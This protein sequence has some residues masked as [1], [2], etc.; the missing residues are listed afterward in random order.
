MNEYTA[1][2][3]GEVLAF[4]EVGLESLEKGEVG[5]KEAV[6]EQNQ[7][8]FVA[9]NKKHGED[10]KSLAKSYDVLDVVET[11]AKATGEKLRAMREIY[12]KE[13]DWQDP[14]ELM[15][16]HGFFEGAALVHWSLI[17]GVAETISEEKVLGL[18]KEGK[19]FH[20]LF[21]KEVEKSLKN[22]GSQKASK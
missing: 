6:G 17:E 20:S 22:I 4:A 8:N 1:K 7:Q 10:I 9:Q 12:I 18:S 15:E 14:A 13:D 5:I 19:D 16:W 3:L 2:K 11:K 21:L